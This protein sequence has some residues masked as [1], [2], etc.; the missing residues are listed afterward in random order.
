LWLQ[1]LVESARD[2]VKNGRTEVLK[3]LI[4]AGTDL[5][6]KEKVRCSEMV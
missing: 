2:A 4:E 3:V 5:E 1:E 6:A